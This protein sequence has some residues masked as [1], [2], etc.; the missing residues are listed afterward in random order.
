MDEGEFDIGI[1]NY[2]YN[3]AKDWFTKLVG[4]DEQ[5]KVDETYT[6]PDTKL[7]AGIPVYVEPGSPVLSQVATD[8]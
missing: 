1:L 6:N 3:C 2:I 4:Y 8:E 5:A 7:Q